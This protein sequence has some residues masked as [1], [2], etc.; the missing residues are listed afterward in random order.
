MKETRFQ[1]EDLHRQSSTPTAADLLAEV[2]LQLAAELF[3]KGGRSG[4]HG[5]PVRTFSPPLSVE[6]ATRQGGNVSNPPTQEIL[7]SIRNDPHSVESVLLLDETRAAMCSAAAY[8][9]SVLCTDGLVVAMTKIRQ[10][11]G[12]ISGLVGFVQENRLGGQDGVAQELARGSF[13]PGEIQD[14]LFI[15][16]QLKDNTALL[17]TVERPL[18]DVLRLLVRIG[19]I[20]SESSPSIFCGHCWVNNSSSAKFCRQCGANLQEQGKVQHRL[21][22]VD[23][24]GDAVELSD[25]VVEEEKLGQGEMLVELNRFVGLMRQNLRNSYEGLQYVNDQSQWE[26][27]YNRIY[28]VGLAKAIANAQIFFRTSKDKNKDFSAGELLVFNAVFGNETGSLVNDFLRLIGEYKKRRSKDLSRK[29]FVSLIDSV[30]ALDQRFENIS[31]MPEF[32]NVNGLA[33]EEAVSDS[34][35]A[36]NSLRSQDPNTGI[37]GEPAWVV[38]SVDRVVNMAGKKIANVLE[39]IY[40]SDNGT[41]H[42]IKARG[43]AGTAREAVLALG[44]SNIGEAYKF[45]KDLLVKEMPFENFK[46]G[47]SDMAG[48]IARD[49]DMLK[50]DFI[51]VLEKEVGQPSEDLNFIV[52]LAKLAYFKTFSDD[53][54]RFVERVAQMDDIPRKWLPKLEKGLNNPLIDESLRQRIKD[55]FAFINSFAESISQAYKAEGYEVKTNDMAGMEAML[56]NLQI[57]YKNYNKALSVIKDILGELEKVDTTGTKS[58]Q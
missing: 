27:W 15:Y 38:N 31:K 54:R 3:E 52:Q 6:P 5:E 42:K 55:L 22:V 16:G 12:P 10:R 40:K 19:K 41:F 4:P 34:V 20:F 45:V 43:L 32:A 18:R 44:S 8:F 49:L 51:N 30:V 21:S 17:N 23:K 36:R 29:D 48:I 33:S 7:Q 1:I 56:G 57:Y 28:S 13:Q 47:M 11:Y 46:L 26:D 39:D 14:F 9:R 24:S 53:L 35:S 58:K 50:R 2:E 37:L 25:P